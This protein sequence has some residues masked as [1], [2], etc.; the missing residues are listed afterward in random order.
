ML[1]NSL[2]GCDPVIPDLIQNRTC[3]QIFFGQGQLTVKSSSNRIPGTYFRLGYVRFLE[4]RKHSIRGTFCRQL[5]FIRFFKIILS[6]DIDVVGAKK[7]W[8][9]HLR[10]KNYSKNLYTIQSDDNICQN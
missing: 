3:Q 4:S 1:G 2:Q 6:N 9:S 7:I 10:E 5:P 8:S